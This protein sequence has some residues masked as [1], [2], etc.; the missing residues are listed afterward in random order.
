LWYNPIGCVA[1]VVF[2]LTLQALFERFGR[3][4]VNRAPEP[5]GAA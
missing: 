2:S 5:P 3:R 1:C 4:P